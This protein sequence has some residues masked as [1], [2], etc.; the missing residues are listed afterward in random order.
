M[1]KIWYDDYDNTAGF[2]AVRD[3]LATLG[4]VD[5]TWRN[6][7]AP[8][9]RWTPE[10]EED[11]DANE[12]RVWIDYY[13]PSKREADDTGLPHDVWVNF[14][15]FGHAFRS[16]EDLRELVAHCRLAQDCAA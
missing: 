8:S 11:D 13:N 6:D 1:G 15:G 12:I 5:S 2:I 7:L 14:G 9:L 3:S 16:W 4:F 10:G